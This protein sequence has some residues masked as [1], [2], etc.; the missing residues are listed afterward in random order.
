MLQAEDISRLWIPHYAACSSNCWRRTKERV[1]YMRHSV[2]LLGM[3]RIVS[4]CWVVKGV[5]QDKTYVVR[6]A[7]QTPSF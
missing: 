4:Q 1:R 7:E 6:V 5:R 2:N 3:D